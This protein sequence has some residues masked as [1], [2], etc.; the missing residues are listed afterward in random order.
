MRSIYV[1]NSPSARETSTTWPRAGGA[2]GRRGPAL[3]V[4][5]STASRLVAADMRRTRVLHV[6]VRTDT[7]HTHTTAL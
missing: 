7:Q 6:R 1:D 4:V 5:S 2:P 3:A